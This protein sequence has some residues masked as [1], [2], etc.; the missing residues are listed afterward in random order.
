MCIR[1]PVDEDIVATFSPIMLG[2]LRQKMR[3]LHVILQCFGVGFVSLSQSFLFVLVPRPTSS[4]SSPQAYLGAIFITVARVREGHNY[5]AALFSSPAGIGEGLG[6]NPHDTFGLIALALLTVQ[7]VTTGAGD[8]SEEAI[9]HFAHD[10][11]C[12]TQILTL[13][14]KGVSSM[15]ST[16]VA[17]STLALWLSTAIQ[18]HVLHGGPPQGSEDLSKYQQQETSAGP[19]ISFAV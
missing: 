8:D 15:S 3:S 12:I 11:V 2:T 4:S 13:L 14:S 16:L 10:A 1:A 9:G 19:K 17:V 18:V 7:I 6:V 5:G